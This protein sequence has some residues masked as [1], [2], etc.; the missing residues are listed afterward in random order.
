MNSDVGVIIV[1]WN[2]ADDT[3]ICVRSVLASEGI[4]P[5]VVIVDNGSSDNSVQQLQSALPTLPLLSLPENVG[6]AG[7]INVALDDIYDKDLEY[8]LLLNNDTYLAPDCVYQ[9]LCALNSDLSAAIAGPLILYADE[10]EYVWYL[11]DRE[12]PLWP[13]P[14]SLI[15][16]KR[17]RDQYKGIL[18]V[19]YVSG[20][21]MLVRCS[22]LKAL[23]GFNE[24]L[25]MH[26][27]DADF[28]WRVRGVGRKILSV[29]DA[30]MWHKVSLSSR[31]LGTQINYYRTRNRIWFYA[32][33]RHGLYRAYALS[34]VLL[35]EL[36]RCGYTFFI[37]RQNAFHLCFKA[38]RHG[39]SGKL[40]K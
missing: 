6:L 13:V 7:G 11:G 23:G 39:I 17:Y 32:T 9:L 18:E 27:E 21:A 3:I 2:L 8:V 4:S 19:D 15:R 12:K 28:C 1:N 14:H 26:Y 22:V 29:P 25:F 38:I 30:R 33:H 34:Y 5:Y 37:R 31:S 20:C 36:I 16:G 40:G 10:P 35:Q 24:Q